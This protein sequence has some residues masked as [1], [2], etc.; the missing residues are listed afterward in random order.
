VRPIRVLTRLVAIAIA[1]AATPALAESAAPD[2]EPGDFESQA[3]EFERRIA[4][5]AAVDP[6]QPDAL[7]ARL[8]Y[9]RLLHR[10]ASD[11]CLPLLDDAERQLAPVLAADPKA[12]VA[13]PDGPGDALSLLQSIQNTRGQCADDEPAARAA[14]EASIAT[15]ERA[16]AALRDNWDYEEMAI[17]R[18]NVAFARRELGDLD[19]ALDDLEQVLA[20]DLEFGLR[21]DLESDYATLLQWQAGGEEPD[22]EAVERW[23]RGFNQTKAR[24]EFAWRPHRAQWSTEL[25]RSNVR[26]DV[27]AQVS[28]R[29]R[30]EVDV[31]RD[32][33]DWVLTTR[34]EG[35]PTVEVSGGAQPAKETE[36]WQGIL[37]GL[38]ASLPETVVGA[39]GTFKGLRNL[40]RH[41]AALLEELGRLAADEEG[42]GDGKLPA[43]AVQAM[44]AV[45][46]PELLTTVASGEWD[47]TVGAWIGA[48]FDH[49]DWY[50]LTFEEPLPGFTEQPVAKTMTFKVSRWLPCA[51]GR[52]AQCVELLVRIVPEPEGIT[53]AVNDFVLRVMP[54]AS[55]AEMERALAAVSYTFDV[56]YRL[57][58]EP[59]TLRPWSLEERKYI[60]VSSIEDGK[61]VVNARRDRT[62]QTAQYG[63]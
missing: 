46:N 52:P 23:V 44:G 2:D 14:F 43:E 51:E 5:L 31:R 49:G 22:P 35:T 21:E 34:I 24:F 50:S 12:L 61:R 20:W 4:E 37:A 53:R 36:R 32:A 62:L 6:L 9:A 40:E 11:E 42:G 39:D 3:R 33:D 10:A 41:R 27:L 16:I 1:C 60:Y 13:W 59:D 58:T 7:D 56:R 45:L 63:D 48:E 15:G 54:E 8:D 28:T 57:V 55:R 26:D 47:I 25:D 38:A 29:Y 30:S 17:A 18:F 19:G